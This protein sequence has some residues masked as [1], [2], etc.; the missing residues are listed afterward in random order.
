MWC[1]KGRILEKPILANKV[2]VLRNTRARIRAELKS[3]AFPQ[4]LDMRKKKFGVKL[5]TMAKSQ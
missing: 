4:A 3:N 1:S 2:I 5:A